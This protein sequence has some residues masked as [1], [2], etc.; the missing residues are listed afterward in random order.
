ILNDVCSPFG[1]RERIRVFPMQT[2]KKFPWKQF[3]LRGVLPCLLA[4]AA[5]FI[6]RYQ[7]E[8]SDGAAPAYLAQQ[9]LT[10]AALNAMTAFCLTLALF[11]LAGRWWLATALS[12]LVFT[13]VALIDY[14]TCELHGA[15]LMP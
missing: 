6:A 5:A 14:Y 8:L 12:G 2:L 9:G 1:Y 4:V 7:L 13:I 11:A 15:A 3:L 10:F